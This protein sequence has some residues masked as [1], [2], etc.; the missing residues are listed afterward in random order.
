MELPHQWFF[1]LFEEDGVWNDP[2]EQ[3]DN[4]ERDYGVGIDDK[5]H[6]LNGFFWLNYILD[7]LNFN[8]ISETVS[9]KLN[10]ISDNSYLV[11]IKYSKTKNTIK[12]VKKSLPENKN[13]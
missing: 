3:G 6:R 5:F 7:Y 8:Q 1:A 13:K 2:E 4:P 11:A 10:S 12:I 9:F